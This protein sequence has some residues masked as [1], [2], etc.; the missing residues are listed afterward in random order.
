MV[1]V[2]W[3]GGEVEEAELLEVE[4]VSLQKVGMWRVFWE[5]LAYWTEKNV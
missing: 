4:W 5:F 3:G 1:D 2:L